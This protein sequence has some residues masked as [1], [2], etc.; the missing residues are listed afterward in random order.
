MS[1]LRG[2][3][4]SLPRTAQK[5]NHRRESRQAKKVADP[6][7]IVNAE[8]RKL[9]VKAVTG[10]QLQKIVNDSLKVSDQTVKRAQAP[11]FSKSS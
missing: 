3:D 1:V 9:R 2:T 8:K 6:N 7:L 10:V 11:I 5:R 4:H